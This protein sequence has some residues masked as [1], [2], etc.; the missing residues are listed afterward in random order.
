MIMP[1]K[2]PCLPSGGRESHFIDYIIQPAFKYEQK[3]YSRY[4]FFLF[5]LVIVSPKLSFQCA[6]DP[7][8]FLL[9]SQLQLIIRDLPAAPL[10]MLPR[11]IRPSF[12]GAFIA[13]TTV[14]L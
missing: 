14:S 7:F 11:R 1:Y 9:F 12:K 4:S 13:V 2:L 10:T 3:V 6:I 5:S 8:Y